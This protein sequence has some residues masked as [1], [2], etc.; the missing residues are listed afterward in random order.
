MGLLGNIYSTIDTQKRKLADLLGNP[1]ESFQQAIGNANDKARALNELTAQ[2]AMEKD[3]YGPKNQQLAGL[4][5][6]AYN[7]IGMM[8]YHGSP[9]KFSKFDPTKIG[10]GEGAQA[11]GYGHY[12]AQSPAVAKE[13]QTK[14]TIGENYVDGELLDAY[15]PK[16]LL[17]SI[18]SQESGNVANAAESL[19]DMASFG[20]SKSIKDSAKQALGLLEKGERPQL[21]YVKPE[22]AFYE[23]DLPD[24]Q[25]AK[26]LD[27]DKPISKQKDVMAALRSEAEARVKA[28]MLPEIR[29]KIASKMPPQQQTGDWMADLFGNGDANIAINKQIDEQAAQE[30][31]KMDLSGLVSKEMDY[32]KPVDMTW[33]MTGKQFYELMSKMQ[34][35]PEKAS[36][37]LKNQGVPGIRYLDQGSRPL[38]VE[39]QGTSNFVVFPGNED[40]LTILKRNNEPVGLLAPQRR[41]FE[42]SVSDAS[43]IFGQGAKRIKYTDPN[44]GGMIDVLQKPDGTASVLGLEVPENMRGQ[45]IGQSLQSQVMQDFPEMMGQVSSK[46]AAKT[47]YRLGRRPPNQPDATLEDVYK[48]MDEYSSVNL[49]SPDMQKRM[50]KSLLD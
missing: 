23:I 18:L 49:V 39:G 9:A 20:V 41:K 44:S 11:F 19:T 3:L 48:I 45:G 8:V 38:G 40:L 24:E 30:L 17:A 32:M 31:S 27:W 12:V 4:L 16:H 10:S 2:A 43:E 34:G 33:E 26:M 15:K 6:E 47:A 37:I 42:T 22:G 1:V 36:A 29:N 25:I 21:K 13:Y 7:P 5:A 14:L 35:S 28:K 50:M 46:A